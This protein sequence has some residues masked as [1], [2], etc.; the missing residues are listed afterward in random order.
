MKQLKSLFQLTQHLLGAKK[1]IKLGK[2]GFKQAR[3]EWVSN[4]FYDDFPEPLKKRTHASLPFRGSEYRQ[5]IPG[6]GDL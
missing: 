1:G 5:L 3:N 4:D 6:E 2:Q